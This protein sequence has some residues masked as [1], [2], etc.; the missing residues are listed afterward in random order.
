MQSKIMKEHGWFAEAVESLEGES[1]NDNSDVRVVIVCIDPT[2]AQDLETVAA[3]REHCAK[4]RPII[5]IIMP[6]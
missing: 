4:R 1:V 6:G 5:P 2:F 3:F